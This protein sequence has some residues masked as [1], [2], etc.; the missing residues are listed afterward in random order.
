MDL[1]TEIKMALSAERFGT[2]LTQCNNCVDNAAKL[3][4]WNMSAA[5]AFFP[6]LSVAEVVL[7]NRIHEA[8][9]QIHGS[10]WPWMS[11]FER[12]LPNPNSPS[13]FNPHREL[14]NTREKYKKDRQTGKVVADLKFAFWQQMLKKNHKIP[15]WNKHL[16]VAFPNL[17]ASLGITTNRNQLYNRVEKIRIL[18]NRIA[19][20]EPI[21][22]RNLYADYQNVID[23]MKTSSSPEFIDWVASGQYIGSCGAKEP[24]LAFLLQNRP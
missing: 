14:A 4:L 15:L 17:D 5:S 3:Y 16:Y 19:H 2:Y 7:R 10:E 24:Y 20:H 8:L 11:G 12:T 13:V 1:N 23:L 21:F 22:A 9:V 6:W 18:R